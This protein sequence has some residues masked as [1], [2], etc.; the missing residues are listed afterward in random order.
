MTDIGK[1][2]A[3][4]KINPGRPKLILF[5]IDGTLISHAG[6]K[7]YEISPVGT[8]NKYIYAVRNCFGFSPEVDF[9]AFHGGIDRHTLWLIC[10]Q[11]GITREA[12]ESN[13]ECLCQHEYEY[14]LRKEID[15]KLYQAI[16]EAQTLVNTL[17]VRPDVYL[18]VITGNIRK[19]AAWKLAVSGVEH[20]FKFGLYGDEADD[21][22]ALAGMAFAR[23]QTACGILFNPED[24]TIV[25]DTVNDIRCGKAI[26]AHT[27][28]VSIGGEADLETL[29]R[30]EPS[31]LVT[32]LGDPLVYQYLGIA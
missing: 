25:G 31:L 13:F 24:V 29:R 1:Q 11:Y 17:A 22:F 9:T 21:R 5:D 7:K 26:D 19:L 4:G 10:Q 8:D 16:P 6:A 14:F 15:R 28:A 3:Q 2:P 32:S 20:H 18:G 12:Y 30:E 23:A 27:I